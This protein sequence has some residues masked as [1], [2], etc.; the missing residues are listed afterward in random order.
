MF[1]LNKI[2]KSYYRFSVSVNTCSKPSIS[3]GSVMPADS[4]VNY[5]ASYE[6]S[7]DV[8]FTI[9]GSTTMMCGAD[10]TFDQTPTCQSKHSNCIARD[11]YFVSTIEG[12]ARGFL[13]KLY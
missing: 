7:C 2:I 9:S 4:T 13:L 11:T 3:D 8:G 12:Q 10:G 1:I 5:E 6:V